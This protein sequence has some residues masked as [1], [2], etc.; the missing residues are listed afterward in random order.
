MSRLVSELVSGQD[1]GMSAAIEVRRLVN[2]FRISQAI[3]AAV[4]LGLPDQFAE[5]P[6]TIADLAS[7]TSCD[8][9]SLYRLLRALATVGV[10]EELEGE[11]FAATALSDAL[12]TDALEPVAGWAAFVGRPSHWQAW[13]ALLHSVRTGEI[14]FNVAHGQ[15]VWEYRAQR[16]DE[17]AAFDAGMT[18]ISGFVGRSVVD[19]YDFGRF[20]ELADIGGGQGRLLAAILDRW[21][22]L[23][24]V[25]FDQPHVVSGASELLE[26]A[27]VA[28]RCRVVPGSFF[29]EVPG[30]CDAYLLKHIVHD[31]PD[32]KAVEILRVCRRDMP[33]TATLLL[34]E[35][36]IQ[37]RNE[38]RDAAF[39]DL[40]MLVQTGGQERTE[41]EY[42]ALLAS[43]GF[44]LTRVVPTAS[45]V[46]VIEA[47][48]VDG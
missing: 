42:R 7:H 47:L 5:G 19:G 38:G 30:G 27:G 4:V 45:D 37:S 18:A 34:L 33:A 6:R 20:R 32:D 12:R 41:A 21:P 22:D 40:N 2:G 46:S 3:H 36:V 31:W 23:H 25:V 44:R 39:S 14:G 10:F 24:G 17:S 16:P 9:A 11:R 48:P 13:G 29:D 26:P 8:P 43:A 1:V 15:D 35:R 28:P